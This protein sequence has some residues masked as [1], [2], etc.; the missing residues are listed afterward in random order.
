MPT[1]Q[2]KVLVADDEPDLNH[3]RYDLLLGGHDSGFDWTLV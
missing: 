2:Y 1:M 3:E